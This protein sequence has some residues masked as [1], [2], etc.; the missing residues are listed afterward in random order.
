VAIVMSGRLAAL[1][2]PRELTR[3]AA[4][5]EVRFRAGP[6]LDLGALARALSIPSEHVVEEHPGDYLVRAPGTPELVADL[7][8]HLRDADMMLHDL[9]VG[10]RSLEEVFLLLTAEGSS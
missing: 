10:R 1:G 3:R 6:G 5:D 2:S 9:H 8:C 7:T 4:A